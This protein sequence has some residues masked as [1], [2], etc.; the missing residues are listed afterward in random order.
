MDINC[1]S[2]K[3]AKNIYY[4]IDPEYEAAR[5]LVTDR[6]G[7]LFSHFDPNLWP[8]GHVVTYPAPRR[9]WWHRLLCIQYKRNDD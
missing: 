8:H 9:R 2:R 3:K 6:G 7:N 4:Y 1:N 5:D